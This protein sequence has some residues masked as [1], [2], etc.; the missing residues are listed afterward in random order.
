VPQEKRAINR[1]RFEA[2]PT[3][4]DGQ[5]IW[6]HRSAL[7]HTQTADGVALAFAQAFQRELQRGDQAPRRAF[8]RDPGGGCFAQD[9]FEPF[10]E[11]LGS[12]GLELL[13]QH[14]DRERMKLDA[15][16]QLDQ[17]ISR[18]WRD[19]RI[20]R[21][22]AQF[23]KPIEGILG[24]GRRAQS[25][26]GDTTMD[27]RAFDAIV[28]MAEIRNATGQQDAR[29]ARTGPGHRGGQQLLQWVRSVC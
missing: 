8:H 7:K 26:Q 23:A 13:G 16:E 29:L 20:G 15:I 21:Q 14:A 3:F 25:F 17:C 11:F 12:A 2:Y 9:L 24:I 19:A 27:P 28:G 1:K 22:F 18:G 4:R 6:L 5:Q 10:A